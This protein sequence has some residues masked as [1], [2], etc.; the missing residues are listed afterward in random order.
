VLT[1]ATLVIEIALPVLLWNRRA[2]PYVIAAGL[3]LHL[4]IELTMAVGFFSAT[5]VT[6]YLSFVE[7]ATA[8]RWLEVVRRRFARSTPTEVAG[9]PV[10]AGDAV[11]DDRRRPGHRAQAPGHR[12]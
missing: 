7:P 10:G 1:Y 12:R 6:L 9:D 4:G 5:A 2:R 11:G 8:E 3:A